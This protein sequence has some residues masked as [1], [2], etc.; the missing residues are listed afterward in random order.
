MKKHKGSRVKKKGEK[1][2]KNPDDIKMGLLDETTNEVGRKWIREPNAIPRICLQLFKK[3]RKKKNI[4][5]GKKKKT[6][7]FCCCCC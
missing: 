3:E 2:K 6:V 5:K 1:K 7:F 4:K